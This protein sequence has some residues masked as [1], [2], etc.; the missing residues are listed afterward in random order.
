MMGIDHV[1]MGPRKGMMNLGTGIMGDGIMW[2]TT[3]Q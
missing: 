1:M 3:T 2:Q